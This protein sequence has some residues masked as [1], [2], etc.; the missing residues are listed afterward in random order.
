MNAAAAETRTR[1][2]PDEITVCVRA[3]AYLRLPR[4]WP[5]Y[6]RDYLVRMAADERPDLATKLRGLTDREL[7]DLY[8]YVRDL[9]LQVQ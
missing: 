3:C 6:F 7:A 4:A 8:D 9:Q 5:D 1:L 2:T